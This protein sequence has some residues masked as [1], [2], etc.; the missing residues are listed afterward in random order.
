MGRWSLQL[1]TELGVGLPLLE[2]REGEGHTD[3][4]LCTL[5][6]VVFLMRLSFY[7]GGVPLLTSLIPQCG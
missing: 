5:S 2:A 6:P 4:D 3:R 7:L 1:R